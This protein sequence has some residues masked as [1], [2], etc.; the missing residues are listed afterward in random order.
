MTKLS[1]ELQQIFTQLDITYPE[2]AWCKLAGIF[3]IAFGPYT[4]LDVGPQDGTVYA[5]H[6]A[7]VAGCAV[8]PEFRK[9]QK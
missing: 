5:V 8:C 6:N 7:E 1:P 3:C 2:N 9:H 4:K